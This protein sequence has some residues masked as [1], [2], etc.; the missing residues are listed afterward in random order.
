MRVRAVLFDIY[1]TL[2]EVGPPPADA[3]ER[4][5]ALW[6]KFLNTRPQLDLARFGANCDIVI[7]REHAAARATGVD[8]PEVYWPDVVREVLPQTASLSAAQFDEFLYS[9][10][11][12][13]H[14]VRLAPDLP[15]LLQALSQHDLLLGLVS[16]CQPYSL[17]ELDAELSRVNLD[18][19][20]FLRELCFLSFEHGFSKPNPHA[21][22]LL[23][24]RLRALGITPA[25]TLMV[26]DR[27][28][29]DIAPAQAQGWQTWLLSADHTSLGGSGTFGELMKH[30]A[31][32]RF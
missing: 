16:N 17:R 32:V 29:N 27:L 1:K 7:A 21:F 22:R 10:T 11:C 6:E 30:L 25:Q 13:W 5:V 28:D 26:G 19:S 12:L 9:Q 4:W 23:T 24:I 2:L 14:T 18:R 15:E 8:F 31:T 3:P 20:L